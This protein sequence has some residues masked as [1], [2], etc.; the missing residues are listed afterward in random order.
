LLGGETQVARKRGRIYE[1]IAR[2]VYGG[3]EEGAEIVIRER[4]GPTGLR[5]IPLS[6]VV[7]LRRTHL[8][9]RDG[10]VIPLHRVVEI[11]APGRRW[12]RVGENA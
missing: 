7:E 10:T 2:L 4:G 6:E 1:E 9:L 3:E 12:S 8:V 5:S 11:R